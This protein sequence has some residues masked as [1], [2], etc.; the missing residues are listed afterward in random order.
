MKNIYEVASANK[1]KSIIIIAVFIAFITAAVFFI[2]QAIGI[3]AGYEPGGLG[4][5]GL[6]LIISGLMSLGS[7]YFSDK[8]VLAISGARPAKR[9]SE[10]NFY[11]A[12]ENLSIAAGMPKPKLYVIEDTAMN[13]FATGR[14]PEHAVVCATTGLIDKLD[15]S[16]LEGVIAHELTHVRNYD[17]RLMSIVSVLVGTV[18]L[19]GDWFLR[20]SWWGRGRKSE[21]G[22]GQIGAILLVVGLVFA[23]LSPIIAQLIQL[24]ISRRREFMADAGSVELTRQPSGLISALSKISSD[25]EVLEAANKATAHLYISNPFK[26]KT[27]SAVGW[28]AGLFNTH[29]P[30]ADR[31]K[32]LQ[33]M[34]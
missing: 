18:A 12:A 8:I 6:A 31:I 24:A 20:M 14:D 17:T 30:I 25:T 26:D 4:I 16:E 1:R 2:S 15:R 3:Y 33:E 23:L 27:K 13:A 34:V 11:T 10:F 7:Y 28:F 21:K 32:A 9:S 29:P 5:A 22:S 19:L